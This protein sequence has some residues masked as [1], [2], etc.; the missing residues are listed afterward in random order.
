[1]QELLKSFECGHI[2]RG[3]VKEDGGEGVCFHRYI[4]TINYKKE[5]VWC[6]SDAK[7]FN[8]EQK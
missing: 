3:C 5:N 6:H 4:L 7:R 2:M 8:L 1:M